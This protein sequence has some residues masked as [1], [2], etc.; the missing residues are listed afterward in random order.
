MGDPLSATFGVLGLAALF[1]TVTEIWSFVDTGRDCSE[2]FSYLRTRLD[3]Q[4]ELF[5]QWGRE[6]GFSSEAGYDNRLDEPRMRPRIEATLHHMKLIF[7]NTDD[8]V[9]TYGIRIEENEVNGVG[10]ASGWRAIWRLSHERFLAILRRN[11]RRLS[12]IKVTRWSVKDGAKFRA[13]VDRISELLNDL[14]DLTKDFVSQSRHEE[15]AV[16]K[17][18]TIDDVIQPEG[19]IAFLWEAGYAET[20]M[21]S[22][23]TGRRHAAEGDRAETVISKVFVSRNLTSDTVSNVAASVDTT[24]LTGRTHQTR[25][26]ITG[27]TAGD[28]PP[29]DV[30]EIPDQVEQLRECVACMEDFSFRPNQPHCSLTSMCKHDLAICT[31]CIARSIRSDL[32][33][34][35]CG[36]IC[37]PECRAKLNDA[38]VH[39]FADWDTIKL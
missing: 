12:T 6:M 37:C 17:S 25:P 31:E 36:R 15:I 28:E 20:V 13:M 27:A 8:L 21:S 22:A 32:Q 16:D 19:Q 26:T 10:R 5:V 18:N 24:F 4:R 38:D 1:T 9:K 23:A 3:N 39:F 30:N 34:W 11:Q 14:N 2:D 29:S 33:T 35:G 7:S